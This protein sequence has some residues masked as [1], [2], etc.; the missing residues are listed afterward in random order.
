MK[1]WTKGLLGELGSV[2]SWNGE[3]V[4][5]LACSYFRM[6]VDETKAGDN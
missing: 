6:V 4:W 3:E 2:Q 5:F 1:G